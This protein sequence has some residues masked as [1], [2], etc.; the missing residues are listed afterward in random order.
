MA[1]ALWGGG[2]G[3]GGGHAKWLVPFGAPSK[4]CLKQGALKRKCKYIQHIYIYMYL[5]FFVDFL[6]SLFLCR[7]RTLHLDTHLSLS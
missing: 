1:G 2:G 4:P 6:F 3:G 5:V 7:C